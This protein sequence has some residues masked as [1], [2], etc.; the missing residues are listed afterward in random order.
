MTKNVGLVLIS[1]SL[2]LNGCSHHTP[3]QD[4][5]Q[6][7]QPQTVPVPSGNGMNSWW[8]FHHIGGGYSGSGGGYSGSGH[9]IGGFH[10]GTSSHGVTSN[11]VRSGGG[12]FKSSSSVTTRGGF[13]A[14]GRSFGG[15]G[16]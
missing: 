5:A 3:E 16:S 9:P 2:I 15:S 12:G 13:G 4:P 10:S 11:G 8:Y 6:E 14:S 7:G 1:S